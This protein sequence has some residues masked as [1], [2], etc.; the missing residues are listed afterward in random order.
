MSYSTANIVKYTY[1]S[2]NLTSVA[3]IDGCG[4]TLTY[5]EC[6]NKVAPVVQKAG[7]GTA[8]EEEGTVTTIERTAENNVKVT[9]ETTREVYIFADC[10]RVENYELQM[11]VSLSDLD[12]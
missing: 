3:N 1:S 10:G 5:L 6:L 11:V 2:A 7:M 4:Y 9:T 8:Q 12:D